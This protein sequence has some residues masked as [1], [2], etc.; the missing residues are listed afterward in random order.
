MQ[1]VPPLKRYRVCFEN[2]G[3][4]AAKTLYTPGEPVEVSY[5]AA[6]DTSYWFYIDDVDFKQGYDPARGTILLRFEMPEHDVKIRVESKNS[7]CYDP[8][9]KGPFEKDRWFCPECGTKN[10]G[11]FCTECGRRKPEK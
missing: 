9:I 11:K 2:P 10:Y 8:N 3:F 4:K 5:P 6:S 1:F 7:M